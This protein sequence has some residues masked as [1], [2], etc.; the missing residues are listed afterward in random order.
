MAPIW[1]HFLPLH[2][3]CNA[4]C[5]SALLL[6]QAVVGPGVQ[7]PGSSHF[8]PPFPTLNGV[9]SGSVKGYLGLPNAPCGLHRSNGLIPVSLSHVSVEGSWTSSKPGS[10]GRRCPSVSACLIQSPQLQRQSNSS[11]GGGCFRTGRGKGW[12]ETERK[13]S[14][15]ALG[16]PAKRDNNSP[17]EG[18]FLESWMRRDP[19]THR[20]SFL[21]NTG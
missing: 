11:G 19:V 3:F 1:C 5:M 21:L 18:T 12:S 2:C 8:L 20:L 6:T 13:A 4:K 10:L 7:I 14:F 9:V 15:W 16:K 17:E